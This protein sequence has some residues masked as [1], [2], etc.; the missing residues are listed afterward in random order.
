MLTECTRTFFFAMVHDQL[1]FRNCLNL[2]TLISPFSL[3]RCALPTQGSKPGKILQEPSSATAAT[4]APREGT[5][6]QPPRGLLDFKL[7]GRAYTSLFC[8]AF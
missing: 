4:H 1:P 7:A 2:L 6:Q 8:F 3:T 5:P